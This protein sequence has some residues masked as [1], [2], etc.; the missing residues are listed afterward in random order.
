[1][2]AQVV[3]FTTF[4]VMTQA[5]YFGEG[6]EGD[7][8]LEGHHHATSY[9]SGHGVA[10]ADH[11]S[12]PHVEHHAPPKYEFKYGVEDLHTGDVKEQDEKREHDFTQSNYFVAEKDRKISVNRIISGA[13]PIP[14]AKW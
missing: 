7:L 2:I 3:F 6:H 9:I 13:V 4:L 8:G 14:I 12:H 5:G 10:I 11:K 1:M